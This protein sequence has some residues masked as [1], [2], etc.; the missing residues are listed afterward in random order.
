MRNGLCFGFFL[1]LQ[2][3][4]FAA[5]YFV[6]ISGSDSNNGLQF[7]KAFKTIQ[8]ATNKVKAGDTVFVFDGLYKGFDHFYKGSGMEG[9][10]IV[11]IAMGNQVVVNQ[12]CGRGYDGINVE[13]SDYIQLIGFKVKSISDPAGSGEDGI[14]V[15]LANHIT[16]RNC[17][18]D[19]CYRGIFTGYTDNFLAEHNVCKNSY[20]E[21]GIYVSNNSDQ[22]VIRYNRCYGNARAAGI[23]LN[24][25]LSS[26]A[27]GLSYNVFIHHNICY[28]NRIGLNLQGIYH[29][30]V[31]NNLL[32]NNGVGG[33][34]NGITLFHGD[35]ATGCNDVKVF[36][37]TVIVPSTSQWAILAIESDS[38]FVWNNI[39]I[40][41]SPKGCLDVESSCTN[42]FGDYN[43][44][45]DRMTID[46]GS[47]YISFK[48]W[49]SQGHDA[50]S[51][52]V[53]DI[54]SLFTNMAANDF[55]LSENSLAVDKG[56]SDVSAVVRDDLNQKTR[57]QGTAYDIGCYEKVVRVDNND[58]LQ[59]IGWTESSTT[60]QFTGLSPEHEVWYWDILGNY[61]F[62]G[63]VFNKNTNTSGI[64]IFIIFDKRTGRILQTGKFLNGN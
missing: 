7:D 33:G 55:Q 50:H 27:P 9:N 6:S 53:T 12:S 42:Y 32:F 19:S 49:Q 22:V 41:L 60:I 2:A 17:E 8:A 13:G 44:L 38:L 25:D 11:Y 34:G 36:N 47:S 1:Y 62:K 18:V 46:Q 39:L 59:S 56:T 37:N 26:G 10:E 28:N 3:I 24:P 54:A 5:N 20:G 57:P 35:A 23:Q 31:Y 43:L 30:W 14:R 45:T 58:P 48:T 15:V 16:V 64:V 40:S 21:H 29:S 4:S 51:L 63:S 61:L 52:L